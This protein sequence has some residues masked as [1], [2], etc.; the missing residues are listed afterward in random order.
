MGYC[1][2]L[3]LLKQQVQYAVLLATILIHIRWV[4]FNDLVTTV[5]LQRGKILDRYSSEILWILILAFKSLER[6]FIH[7][8]VTGFFRHWRE[9]FQ[10]L[11]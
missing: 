6:A 5:T 1:H 2:L 10:V 11:L 7:M 9:L 8:K 4:L 3:I